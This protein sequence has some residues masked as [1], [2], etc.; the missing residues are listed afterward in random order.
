[1]MK[2]NLVPG[3]KDKP[4]GLCWAASV[5]C[6]PSRVMNISYRLVTRPL[7]FKNEWTALQQPIQR[8][9]RLGRNVALRSDG[10]KCAWVCICVKEWINCA[11]EHL[12]YRCTEHWCY[13]LGVHSYP[14]WSNAHIFGSCCLLH[15]LTLKT[16]L[17]FNLSF[18]L[19][20]FYDTLMF[21][22]F[23]KLLI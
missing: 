7:N 19:V 1:M 2:H 8:K 13:I 11:C 16:F 23:W 6:R 22:I 17:V 4:T 12:C 18:V 20:S 10:T 9:W 14:N 21:F 3:V 5:C 15:E